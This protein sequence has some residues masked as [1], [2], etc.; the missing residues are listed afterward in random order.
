MTDEMLN[1]EVYFLTRANSVL[2]PLDPKTGILLLGNNGIEFRAEKTQGYIQIPWGS[3]AR[4][5]VQMF[6]SGKY[7][8]G[9]FIETTDKQDLEFIVSDAKT[10]LK[11]MR[12]HLNRNQFVVNKSNLAGIFKRKNKE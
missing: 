2:N 3:I 11:E 1:H 7:I 12:K 5:R 9:F 8:R 4:V 6:F 10:F